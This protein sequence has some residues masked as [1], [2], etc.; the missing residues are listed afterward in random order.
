MIKHIALAV[1]AV[2]ATGCTTTHQIPSPRDGEGC[3]VERSMT[4]F[5][6][7]TTTNREVVCPPPHSK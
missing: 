2:M 7:W 4:E 3:Y 5:G 1:V 6:I